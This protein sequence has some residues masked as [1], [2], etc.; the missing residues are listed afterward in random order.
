MTG[1]IVVVR[2]RRTK[3]E[4]ALKTI[5]KRDMSEKMLNIFWR[6]WNIGVVRSR[7]LSL[8]SRFN[9]L[10]HTPQPNVAHCVEIFET[11]IVFRSFWSLETAR[12]C[13][14]SS[15]AASRKIQTL[16]CVW[17][18]KVSSCSCTL[19]RVRIL[20]SIVSRRISQ[21]INKQNTGTALSIVTS[22]SII[23]F[24][25]VEV[26]WNSSIL[27]WVSSG[28][29]MV[30]ST[31]K[32]KS[33]K[34]IQSWELSTLLLPKLCRVIYRMFKHEARENHSLTH[35]QLKTNQLHWNVRHVESWLRRFR[36]ALWKVPV[37]RIKQERHSRQIRKRKK[38]LKWQARVG[39]RS[40]WSRFCS[41]TSW[42]E[43]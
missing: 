27:D 40:R 17:I 32:W 4:F 39:G 1:D 21:R 19:S 43:S 33:R 24:S 13:W 16:D 15:K 35:S 20:F 3:N 31:V 42:F 23:L 18:G 12:I 41:T 34:W 29:K 28:S 36:V 2:E 7:K 10:T 30:K 8:S 37:Q 26:F 38:L 22:N 14:S 11:P 6:G 9:S 5:Q 25:I